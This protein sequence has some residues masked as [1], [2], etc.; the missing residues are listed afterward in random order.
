M[1]AE[2]CSGGF[3]VLRSVYRIYWRLVGMHV[4]LSGCS[5]YRRRR[6]LI[7]ECGGESIN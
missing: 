2:G 5:L 6:M 1:D 4:V 7:V 3:A